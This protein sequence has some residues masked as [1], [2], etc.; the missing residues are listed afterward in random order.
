MTEFTRFH[1]GDLFCQ[2][3]NSF[4]RKMTVQEVMSSLP[5][6]GRRAFLTAP[7]ADT[8]G[9]KMLKEIQASVLGQ[10]QDAEAIKKEK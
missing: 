6:L 8:E 2:V 9:D 4:V 3:W 5:A 10:L 7:V 1:C